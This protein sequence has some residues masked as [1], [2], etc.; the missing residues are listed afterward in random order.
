MRNVS[1]VGVVVIRRT[2][3]PFDTRL[4]APPACD[5]GWPPKVDQCPVVFRS[6][7]ASVADWTAKMREEPCCVHE[8]SFAV[9][10]LSCCMETLDHVWVVAFRSC[11]TKAPFESRE[12]RTTVLL[13]SMHIANCDAPSLKFVSG[14]ET[15]LS[16]SRICNS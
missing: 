13:V 12:R 2:P 11:I 7:K 8:R 1:V 14:V 9:D 6:Y 15:S 5:N 16:M 3:G 4:H 10:G